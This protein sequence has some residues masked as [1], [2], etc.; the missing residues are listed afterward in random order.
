MPVDGKCI[1]HGRT[2]IDNDIKCF[3]HVT[4]YSC[5]QCQAVSAARWNDA[6]INWQMPQRISDMTY[7]SISAN[8]YYSADILFG[9][10]FFNEVE[11][12]ISVRNNKLKGYTGRIQRS[13]NGI[14]DVLFTLCT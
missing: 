3:C 8:Y 12:A 7:R 2:P 10:L 5:R 6:K 1:D 11:P 4:W 14:N 9:D 13:G